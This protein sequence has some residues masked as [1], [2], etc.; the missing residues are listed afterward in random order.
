MSMTTPPGWYA[1]PG[2]PGSERWW[3]GNGWTAHTRPLGGGASYQQGH[4]P[5]YQPAPRQ[6]G[7]APRRRSVFLGVVAGGLMLGATVVAGITL[8]GDDGTKTVPRSAPTTSEPAGGP[9]GGGDESPT[10]EPSADPDVLVDQLNG[11]TLPIPDDW[12]KSDSMVDRAVTMTTV[13]DRECP[14]ETNR[15][16]R[17]GR[18]MSSTATQT[19]AATPEALAKEDIQDASDALYD[20]DS[21]GNAFYGGVKSH[22]VVKSGAVTVAGRTG[23][24]VRWKVETG[25]GPGGHV[26]SLAFPSTIGAESLIVVRFA[27]DAGPEGPP[28]SGMDT[29]TKGIRAIGDTTGGVGSSIGPS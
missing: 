13:A 10:A 7:P 16:C 4:Q 17:Y 6:P 8:F 27:F 21:I 15:Y 11:I 23:Y 18:V 20:E 12:E 2:V 5:S 24:L 29:I 9:T 14:G 28:L 22:T 26:Q 3:D 25:S 19:D 1:D